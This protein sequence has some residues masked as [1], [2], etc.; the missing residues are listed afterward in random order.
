MG[1]NS[2]L[3]YG[4][5]LINSFLGD[6]ATIS[7]CEVLNSLIFPGHEQHHNNSFLCAATVYGQ[8]NIAAGATIGSN[9][10]SRANDGEIVA[11]RGF[12]P[13]LCVSLKHNSKFASFTLIAK[14]SYPSEL[15]IKTPFSLVINDEA[16]GRLKVFPGFWFLYNMYAL[17]RNSWKYGA[18]DKR[19]QKKQKLEFDYLAPDTIDEIFVALLLL[20]EWVGKS[21][22]K[23]FQDEFSTIGKKLLSD[24]SYCK[25]NE[26]FAFGMEASKRPVEIIKAYEGYHALKDAV[27]LYTTQVLTSFC[28]S[29]N[30]NNWAAICAKLE[31]GEDSAWLNI[32]GQL[33][34]EYEIEALKNAIRFGELNSWDEVH[35][36]YEQ[37]GNRYPL[38]KARHAFLALSKML[39]KEGQLLS[40]DLFIA[41]L[42]RGVEINKKLTT[43]TFESRN[44]DYE[45]PFRKMVYDNK[46]EMEAVI[47]KIEEN[48]FIEQTIAASEEL[49]KKVLSFLERLSFT[50]VLTNKD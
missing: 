36:K 35:D 9:H 30:L 15:N 1:S 3:K 23:E 39:E 47:G 32:G 50:D 40:S 18:R 10:N 12:W 19:N 29:E 24:E 5:R 42:N 14:G 7:C 26:I 41:Y 46:E 16:Q 45:H 20:E 33:M 21:A 6:N 48:T 11:G 44:K 34:P 13:G 8:S 27:V 17:A 25:E 4:A 28:L 38:Q 22:S 2:N 49:E 43:R 31:G 37:M